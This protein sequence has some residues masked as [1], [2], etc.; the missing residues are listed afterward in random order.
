MKKRSTRA[1]AVCGAILLL[2]PA[3]SAGEPV[4]VALA[5]WGATAT[6]SS[7]YGPDYRA[8]NVLD[9]RWAKRETDKWNSAANKVPHWLKIDLGRARTIDRIVVRHEGVIG[10]HQYTTA[11]FRLERS[12]RPDGPWVDL[13][14][15]VKGNTRGVTQHEFDAVGTRYL[16][17]FITKAEQKANAYGRIFEVEVYSPDRDLKLSVP[18]ITLAEKLVRDAKAGKLGAAG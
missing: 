16:R 8:G 15:P 7:E 1:A 6:A 5:E 2:G 18:D 9:G 3:A 10:G 13:C 14:D 12:D 11:D 17:V 4:N